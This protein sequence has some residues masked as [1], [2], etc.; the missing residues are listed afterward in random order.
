MLNAVNLKEKGGDKGSPV[1][2]KRSD[3]KDEYDSMRSFQLY[4]Q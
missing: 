3:A 1:T 4:Q 2:R